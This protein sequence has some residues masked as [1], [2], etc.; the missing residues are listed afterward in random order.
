MRIEFGSWFDCCL[1]T[2]R[3]YPNCTRT[4]LLILTSMHTI[5]VHD[6]SAEHTL[7]CIRIFAFCVGDF[8]SIA[9]NI[10][11]RFICWTYFVVFAFCLFAW[12]IL[13]PLRVTKLHQNPMHRIYFCTIHL[14][15][16][17]FIWVFAFCM[18]DFVSLVRH[19]VRNFV[20]CS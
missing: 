8:V 4:S 16:C 13:C 11:A 3:V 7:C 15:A 12:A 5:F 17:C 10:C 1:E 18:G 19:F 20:N 2:K 9:P 6:S 14:L